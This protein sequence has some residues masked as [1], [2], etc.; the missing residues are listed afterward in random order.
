MGASCFAVA[1]TFLNHVRKPF[2]IAFV[3]VGM[4]SWDSFRLIRS[5]SPPS[6]STATL[7]AFDDIYGH[8]SRPVQCV[9]HGK[10]RFK[11]HLEA[12]GAEDL[13]RRQ[14]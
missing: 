2:F 13:P 7:K 9:Q 3:A 6:I 10:G 12:D 5:M 1:R 14:C 8:S 4:A 11:V